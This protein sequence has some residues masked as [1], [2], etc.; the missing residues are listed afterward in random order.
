MKV[1]YSLTRRRDTSDWLIEPLTMVT[2][3]RRLGP[4]GWPIIDRDGDFY[5]DFILLV[6]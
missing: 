6:Y 4:I 3:V 2:N 5:D 1:N